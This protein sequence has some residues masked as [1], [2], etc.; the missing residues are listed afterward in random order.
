MFTIFKMRIGKRAPILNLLIL[1]SG[2]DL[3]YFDK[4]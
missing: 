1:V 3:M 2:S 4:F